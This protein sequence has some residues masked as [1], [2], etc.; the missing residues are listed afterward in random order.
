MCS[1]ALPVSAAARSRQGRARPGALTADVARRA[2][3]RVSRLSADLCRLAWLCRRLL[4]RCFLILT[5][6]TVAGTSALSTHT[7]RYTIDGVVGP[8]AINIGP[9]HKQWVF[10]WPRPRSTTGKPGQHG[11]A[12][13]ARQ[14][15]ASR[16][17][18]M[19]ARQGGDGCG[20]SK[21]NSWSA[22]SCRC[23]KAERPC[24]KGG[25]PRHPL[26]C[27]VRVLSSARITRQ[28]PLNVHDG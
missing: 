13:L 11:P 8:M 3:E 10:D 28:T 7:C 22:V 4:H 26:S 25:T 21:R 12:L 9:E 24:E 20:C 2:K 6:R 1:C 18:G 23:Q 17:S 16:V 15:R 27:A 5:V 19:A 14:P